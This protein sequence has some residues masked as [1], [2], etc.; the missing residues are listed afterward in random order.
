VASAA[1]KP[2][3]FPGTF[4]KPLLLKYLLTVFLYDFAETYAS[5]IYLWHY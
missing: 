1:K 4:I 2:E 3:Y 5:S